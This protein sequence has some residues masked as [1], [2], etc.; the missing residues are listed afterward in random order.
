M[1]SRERI[2]ITINHKEPDRVPLDLGGSQMTGIAMNAYERLVKYLGKNVGKIEL[3]DLILHLARPHEVILSTLGVDTRGIF[4]KNSSKWT[5]EL[6]ENENTRFFTD[7]F[8]II[9]KNPKERGYYFDPLGSPFSKPDLEELENHPWP[10]GNDPT[11][12]KGL[13]AE[14]EK[15]KKQTSAA[16]M[17]NMNGPGPFE[18]AFWFR[19]HGEFF[20][21]LIQ[22]QTFAERLIGKLTD[23]KLQFWD[24]MLNELGDIIDIAVETCDA[25]S[26]EGPLV[27][28]EMFRKYA[29]QPMKRVNEFIKSKNPN[30]K[31]LLH[32][33]GSIYE[34][35]PDMIE[36]GIDIINPIQISARNMDPKVL[37]KE[38]GNDITFWGGVDTKRL[39]PYGKPKDVREEVKRLIDIFAPGGGFVLTSVHNILDDVPPENVMAMINT[40][41]EEGNY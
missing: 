8:G 19:G 36:T 22:N 28:P 7:E 20:I 30:I 23:I 40:L 3:L 12:V 37:K 41:M 26:E 17:M 34:L 16:I 10:K 35:L 33:C 38:F 5:L 14:A 27:S 18:H 25:G 31:I 1:T 9:W 15:L 6:I 39:L 32:S 2:L 13:R 11:R 24:L 29:I 4:P 21:D